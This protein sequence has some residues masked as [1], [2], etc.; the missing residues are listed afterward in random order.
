MGIISLAKF[1][2]VGFCDDTFIEDFKKDAIAPLASM[3]RLPWSNFNDFIYDLLKVS[4]KIFIKKPNNCT[5]YDLTTANLQKIQ[6]A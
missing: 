2:S 4:N 5:K 6:I 3:L 1:L